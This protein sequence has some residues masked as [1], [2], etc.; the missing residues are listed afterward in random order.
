[1]KMNVVLAVLTV[2]TYHTRTDALARKRD[3]RKLRLL[4]TDDAMEKGRPF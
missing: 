1:M 4:M 3:S 2:T